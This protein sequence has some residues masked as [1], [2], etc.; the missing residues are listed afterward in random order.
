M[1]TFHDP[2]ADAA[3][4]SEALRGL[5]HATR[6]FMDPADTYPVLGDLLAGTRSL[7]QVIDQLASAH[8]TMQTRAR[9]DA[10]SQTAGASAAVTAASSMLEAAEI[11]DQAYDRLEAAM[12]HSGR[13]AWHPAEPIMTEA[14]APRTTARA[15][16]LSLTVWP[17]T[18][19]GQ[20]QRYSYT[21][22]D[23]TTG[24][25]V[26]GGDLFTGDGIPLAPSQAIRDLA[27]YLTAAGDAYQ[28]T[29]D[30]PG[31]TPE[32]QP[33]VPDT[34]AEAARHNAAELEKLAEIDPATA[35]PAE[36]GGA[37]ASRWISV[38]FLQGEHAD[39]TLD[40]IDTDGTDAAI[41]RLTAYDFGD[42]TTQAALANGYLYDAPPSGQLDRTATRGEYTLTYNHAFGY[43]SLLRAYDPGATPSRP[44]T[45]AGAREGTG[46]AT[47]PAR[48]ADA[49][50]DWFARQ[51]GTAESGRGLAL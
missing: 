24:E 50:T 13:I 35:E 28:Y 19:L 36:S 11:L 51:P 37:A 39:R 42:E 26:R 9:D 41:D 17:T 2:V 33:Q 27:T 49:A 46:P 18:P 4:A 14:D 3:E 7:K 21:V 45:P 43:V 32:N 12:S 20:R 29:L 38:V 5:A 44:D 10:G 8:T 25:S 6:A 1:P 40:L 34:V 47:G 30:H 23:T 48:R 22:E 16:T 31:S 15:G